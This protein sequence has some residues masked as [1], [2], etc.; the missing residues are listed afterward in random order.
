MVEAM[1]MVGAGFLLGLACR[2]RAAKVYRIRK[3]NQR[4]RAAKKAEQRA[5]TARR[6]ASWEQIKKIA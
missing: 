2:K 5:R 3:A 1:V 4:R 6:P